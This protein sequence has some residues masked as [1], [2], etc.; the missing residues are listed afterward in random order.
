MIQKSKTTTMNERVE[1]LL[2]SRREFLEKEKIDK[3]NQHLIDIGLYDIGES[4]IWTDDWN[5]DAKPGW[6]YDEEKGKYYKVLQSQKKAIEVTD[7]EYEEICK[8]FP[9]GKVLKDA[10]PINIKAERTLRTIAMVILISGILSSFLIVVISLSSSTPILALI[11][12][13]CLLMTLYSLALLRTFADMSITLKEI[14][15]QKE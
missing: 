4:I 5:D 2:K 1:E 6:K 12:I 10:A 11:A 7:E 15:R 14:E 8:L 9:E 13:P 3:R